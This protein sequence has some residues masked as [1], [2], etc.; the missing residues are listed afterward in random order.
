MFLFP[1]TCIF[2]KDVKRRTKDWDN[3]GHKTKKRS[4]ILVEVWFVTN[5]VILDV[6]SRRSIGKL[7]Y[8]LP[9]NLTLGF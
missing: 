7:P 5:K 1:E 2:F 8:K 3:R 6:Y 4:K 9:N